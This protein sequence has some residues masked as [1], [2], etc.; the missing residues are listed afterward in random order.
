MPPAGME[1]LSGVVCQLPV[2][3]PEWYWTD[4]PSTVTAA[5]LRFVSS[6]KSLVSVAPELPPPP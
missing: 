1:P 4:Q 3:L 5:L 2:A 6:M